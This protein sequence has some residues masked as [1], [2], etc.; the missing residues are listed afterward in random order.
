MIGDSHEPTAEK[1]VDS[2][3]DYNEEEDED[4]DPTKTERHADDDVSSDSDEETE[5]RD[6]PS[7][8][9]E[10]PNYSNIESETGGL[11]KTRR[12]RQV[13]EEA[14]R[15]RKYNSLKEGSISTNAIS[16]W[17]DM[18]KESSARLSRHVG[19]NRSVISDAVEEPQTDLKQEQIT[20]ERTYKFAGETIHEKKTVPKFSAEGQEY[21]KN[22]KFKGNAA[23]VNSTSEPNE[24]TASR[25]NLRRPLKR[26]PILEKII[27]GSIKPK[28]TTLEK[29]KLD[30][31]NYVDKEGITDELALHNRDGYLAKQD[32]LDRVE[33]HKDKKYK[34]FRKT[35]LAMQLQ[36][37]QR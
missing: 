25:L 2:E 13:E 16:T 32:F 11:V 31:V 29:S 24:D 33:S 7:T 14:N 20:I 9:K 18:M 28:L 35:Q 30:W 34:A 4:F 3:E 22:L 5:D 27:S 8:S 12:A 19:S 21:I 23:T 17:E 6:V 15:K 26:E 10:G 36:E 37:Q 1:P